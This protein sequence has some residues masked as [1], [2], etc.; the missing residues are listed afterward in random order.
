MNNQ[1]PNHPNRQF[2]TIRITG[3]SNKAPVDVEETRKA[4]KR[5]QTALRIFPIIML[6]ILIGIFY[7]LYQ[8]ADT[9]LPM[10]ILIF[11]FTIMLIKE[12]STLLFSFSM[13]KNIMR[14]ISNLKSAVDEVA[15]GNYGYT[16]DSSGNGMVNDLV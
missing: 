7:L 13:R 4:F 6:A 10:F 14:P 15:K 11:I 16:I 8:L 9:Q 1:H 5:L 2:H 12:L 3:F